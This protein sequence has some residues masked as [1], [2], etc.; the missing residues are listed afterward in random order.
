MSKYGLAKSCSAVT[1]D[2]PLSRAR[3]SAAC[4]P[5][6]G[7]DDAPDEEVQLHCRK[8]LSRSLPNPLHFSRD[9]LLSAFPR[10]DR[11]IIVHLEVQTN[12]V[13]LSASKREQSFPTSAYE[14]RR[15]RLLKRFGEGLQVGH[16]VVFPQQK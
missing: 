12:D 1:P 8:S 15:M 5:I 2:R 7:D 4:W 11:A 6:L 10:I 13:G 14:E 16:A 3:R 9:S